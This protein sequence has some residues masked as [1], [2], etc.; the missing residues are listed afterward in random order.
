MKR[1]LLAMAALL[2]GVLLGFHAQP[3]RADPGPPDFAAQASAAGLS[4][5]EAQ[6]LQDRVDRYLERLGGTQRGIDA[7]DLDGRAVLRVTVPGR[8][9]APCRAYVFCA[10]AHEHYAGDMLELHSC[11][12]FYLPFAGFGSYRNN[13]LPG[14]AALYYDHER[15]FSHASFGGRAGVPRTSWTYVDWVRPC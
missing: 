7:I 8:A 1:G 9:A 6:A 13:Q 10:Y 14:T 3:A 4:G 15:R 12:Y 11:D 2:V 5:A